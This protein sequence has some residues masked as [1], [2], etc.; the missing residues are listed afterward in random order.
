MHWSKG[1]LRRGLVVAAVAAAAT[2]GLG[3][4]PRGV[5]LFARMAAGRLTPIT[6][7]TRVRWLPGTAGYLESGVDSVTKGR[8]FFRVEPRSGRRTPLFDRPTTER[9]VAEYQRVS[10]RQTSGLPFADFSYELDNRA[11]RF[12]ADGGP[13]L[14][15][16]DS[17]EL[18]KLAQPT[19][20]GP[21]DQG[22]QSAGTFSPDFRRYAF[23][24][25]YDNLFLL[26][27][28]T[29]SEERLTTGTSEDN[30]VGFLGATPWFVWS[31][32]SRFLAYLKAEQ[33]GFPEYPILRSLEP[34]AKVEP[35]RYPFTTTPTAPLE[36]WVVNVETREHRKLA[37]N[38][39]EQPFIRE[40]AWLP[41][42]SALT[43]QLVNRWDSRVE[44]RAVDPLTG[45]TRMLVAD[46]DPAYLDP[47]DNF[48]ILADGKRFLFSS[49]RSGWRHLYLYDGLGGEPRQLTGGEWVTA[50]VQHV[51]E[52]PGRGWIYF[53]GYTDRGLERHLFRVRLDGTGL[54]RLTPE[55]GSH[56][57][58]VDPSGRYFTDDFS[59]L[60]APRKVNLRTTDG[61]LVRT[62]ATT[63]VDAVT[64]LGLEPPELLSLTAADG[65][66]PMHG[67][68]FR[69]VGFDPSKR[70]PLVV[71][72]Y[73]GP[74]TKAIRN[75]YETTDFRAQLAQLGFLV[76]EFD[77]RGTRLREKTYQT[78]NYLKLGQADV[79]DQAAAVRQLTARSYVDGARVGVT[80]LS[81]GG[82]L[83]LMMILRYP[84]VYQ[85]A[86][87]GAPLTDVALGPRQYIGRF[88]RTPD[89]NAEGYA[90]ANVLRYA[91]RLRGRLLIYHGTNDR[92]ALL[93]N[94]YQLVK[95]LVD[96][97]K[98][99]DMMIYPDGV[100]VLAGKDA[101]HQVKTTVAYFL[102]HLKPEGWEASRA[103]IWAQ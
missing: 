89:A 46:E 36:L 26:D 73:G 20:T 85:V 103:A 8:T 72:V 88:M 92:N 66:T 101:I 54:A 61:A 3:A 64:A 38:T 70:Y 43:Y 82:Y 97:G 14:Y 12:T 17:R 77:G 53:V 27:T 22:T 102:E 93:G 28:Q 51:D 37:A 40:L 68:L 9:V 55:P 29:G 99:V 50:E 75:V 34:I 41:D 6:G 74:H 25:D 59:A 67:M 80:G 45:A 44:V 32:D 96:L 21:L 31:P 16:L 4:Q 10:G 39:T 83:T 98:P 11:I 78:A 18:R 65:T 48:R 2:S 100:H 76:A 87:S 47:P 84:E 95:K 13:W 62:L 71:S 52:A 56:A 60:D 24:R 86:V 7:T 35:M 15:R 42:G 94:T 63:N 91:D 81:H 5:E 30:T 1:P 23:I 58:S 79:D 69:P 49:E 33:R 57:V 90:A 19:R